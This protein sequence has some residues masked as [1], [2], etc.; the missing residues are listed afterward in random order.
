MTP[1]IILQS[2]AVSNY[3]EDDNHYDLEAVS[4]DSVNLSGNLVI[5]ESMLCPADI[6]DEEPVLWGGTP[7]LVDPRDVLPTSSLYERISDY[8]VIL[9]PT[10]FDSDEDENEE[11]TNEEKFPDDQVVIYPNFVSEEEDEEKEEKFPDSQI[12]IHSSLSDKGFEEK[13]MLKDQC[14]LDNLLLQ[15]VLG[16]GD[17]TDNVDSMALLNQGIMMGRDTAIGSSVGD[18]PFHLT[19]I[20]VCM[21]PSVSMF[22]ISCSWFSFLVRHGLSICRCHY[23]SIA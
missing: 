6:G 18:A 4:C 20:K 1:R 14:T 19:Q 9:H 21:S 8:R 2:P 3:L 16:S 10:H 15:S 5:A 7:E 13:N 12:I 23:F 22:V 17:D 11:E